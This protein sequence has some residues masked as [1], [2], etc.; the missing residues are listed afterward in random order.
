MQEEQ[1]THS[2]F[3]NQNNMSQIDDSFSV[4]DYN[5]ILDM[6]DANMYDVKAS[7]FNPYVGNQNQADPVEVQNYG[8]MNFHQ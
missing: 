4:N 7:C 6:S 2:I 5:D 3:S 1:Q 8:Q